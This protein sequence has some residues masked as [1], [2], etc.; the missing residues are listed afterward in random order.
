METRTLLLL[1]AQAGAHV[2]RCALDLQLSF[3]LDRRPEVQAEYDRALRN[4]VNALV[5]AQY[6]VENP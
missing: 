2:T 4:A 5:L 6:K 1:I 3:D